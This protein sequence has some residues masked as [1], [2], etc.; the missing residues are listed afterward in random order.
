VVV[1]PEMDRL[2]LRH[3]ADGVFVARDP[4]TESIERV[5][6]A[7]DEKTAALFPE[8][9]AMRDESVSQALR[10][11]LSGLY[12]ALTR[13]IHAMH[14]VIA[15]SLPNER[16]LPSRWS[17][18]LRGALGLV[19]PVVAESVPFEH[20]DPAWYRGSSSGSPAVTPPPPPRPVALGPEPE[21]RT[22]SLSH[23]TPSDLTQGDRVDL[24]ALLRVEPS[25]ALARGSLLHAWLAMI[26][27]VEDGI[28]TDARLRD[29][30]RALGH[31]TSGIDEH[32]REFRGLLEHA[33]VRAALTRGRRVRAEVRREE[34]FA[35]RQGNRILSG[36]FD[37]V[38]LARDASGAIDDVALIEFKT[39]RVP[40]GQID[41]RVDG[42]RAQVDAYRYALERIT[43]VSGERIRAAVLFVTHGLAVPIA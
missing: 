24:A 20:G 41:A 31:G 34:P 15:P 21:L 43:G 39:D 7:V 40:D 25:R 27:W 11:S 37:R 35:V 9:R 10:E 8:I 4:R 12:V 17:G 33:A 36:N 14:I 38:V 32:L 29:R 30:A 1:L 3:R 16:T 13:A 5:V 42:Y 18:V 2:M 19:G 22:R 26:E 28:P 23:V 6:R